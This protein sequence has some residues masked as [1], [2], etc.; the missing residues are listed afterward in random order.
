MS[1]IKE[2]MRQKIMVVGSTILKENAQ[3]TVKG[4]HHNVKHV[5]NTIMEDVTN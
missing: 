1:I 4:N 3:M 2:L 5:A